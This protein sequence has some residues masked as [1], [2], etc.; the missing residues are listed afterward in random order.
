MGFW[1]TFEKKRNWQGAGPSD[2][3]VGQVFSNE[4]IFKHATYLRYDPI[5]LQHTS[6]RCI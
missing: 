4:E 1:A 6:S 5:V 3:V 2:V